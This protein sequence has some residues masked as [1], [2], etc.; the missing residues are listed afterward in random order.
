MNYAN[1]PISCLSVDL[2]VRPDNGRIYALA[3]VRTDRSQSIRSVR[4]PDA[5]RSL[6]R[7]IAQLDALAD[8]VD[9][10]LG[11]NIIAHDMPHLRAENPRLRLLQLPL[12]DTLRLSPL[13]HPAHPYH[14]LVKHY[15]EPGLIRGQRNDPHLDSLLALK[16]FADQYEALSGS[17][18]DLLTAW[19]WL[20][21][22]DEGTVGFDMVF[23][24]VRGVARPS[25][26]SGRAAAIAR[27]QGCACTVASMNVLDSEASGWPLAFA[28]AWL[29]VAE[30]NSVMPP[31]VR[32]QFPEAGRLV[33]RL[34]DRACSDADCEWCRDRHDAQAELKRW[35]GFDN[36][37]PEPAYRHGQ[38][39][40]RLVVEAAMAGE[41]LLAI[42]PTGAGKSLCY[43]VPALSRYA[44]TGALTVVISPL[45]ALMADQVAGLERR[46]ISAAVTINGMLSMPE[47]SD[48]LDRVRLGEAGI[49]L[50]SPEQL[51][52]VAIRRTLQQREI[53][54]WVL[55]EA[56]CLSQWGHDFRPDYRYVGRFIRER[57]REYPPPV[58][59]LTATAKPDVRD[60]IVNY[61]RDAMDVE[62]R[63]FDTG[64][65]R[66]N[67]EFVVVETSDEQK[68]E[69]VY[70]LLGSV[71]ADNTAGGAI[72]YCATRTRTEQMAA[73]LREKDVAASH[74][75]AG[76]LPDTKRSVQ[77]T[78]INGN[79]QVIAATSA[80]GMGI[81]KP[82]V[83]VV[84]HADIPGSL[85]NYLQE[86]GRA[87]RDQ[88]TARCVLLYTTQDVERQFG[89]SARSRLQRREIQAVM[90]AL[91]NLDRKQRLDG[92]VEATT[93][94]ILLEDEG[95]E[96][97][98]DSA[99]D[100]TRVRTAVAWLE[101]AMLVSREENRVRV[102]PSSLRVT[103]IQ[104][105]RALLA[106]AKITDEH[107]SRL[108]EIVKALFDAPA[109]Q[110]ISTD[111][112]M[113]T[114]GLS[115]EGVRAALHNL[116][117]LGIASNDTV[118]TVFVHAG[119]ARSSRNRLQAAM[120]LEKALIELLREMAPDMQPGDRSVF[121]LRHATQRLKSEGHEGALPELLW[122]LLRSIARD[123]RDEGGTSGSL[124]VRRHDAETVQVT[125]RRTWSALRRTAELRRAAARRLLGHFLGLLPTGAQGTDLLAETTLG[126]LVTVLQADLVI[127]SETRDPN[128]L[129]DRA[130]LWL[131][132][133][134]VIQLN[135]G[136]TVFRPAMAIRIEAERRRR[137]T[138]ADFASLLIHYDEQVRQIHVMAEYAERGLRSMTGA[139][140]LA[141]DYFSL[142]ESEF[143]RRWLPH[144][145]AE[146]SRQT[147]AES[148]RAIVEN[149]K[150]PDQRAI[151]ADDRESTNMLVLAG[152]GSG[153]TRVL[154][155]RIA[156]L[157]R[158][159]RENPRSII[160]LTYN[161]H[162]AI[163]IR[164]RLA[165]LVGDDARGVLVMTCH[166]L[167]MRLVGASYEG[168]SHQP[169]SDDFDEILKQAIALLRGD[170][171]PPD[172]ADELRGRLLAGFR[173]VLI[174]E[175]QDIT[176]AQYDLIS[177][178]AGRTLSDA[179]SK[180]T[181][182]AVGDD[183]QNIYAFAGASV[184]FIRRFA[185]DYDAHSSY[186]TGN[187]RSTRH[188]IEAANA[189]IAPARERMKANHPIGIDRARRNA[190][191]GGVWEGRDPVAGG[192][193]QVLPAGDT[194]LSQAQAAINELKRLA[195]LDPDW[196]WSRCAFIAREWSLLDPVRSLCEH[197]GIPAQLAHEEISSIWRL[198]ETQALV[199]W[200]RERIAGTISSQE[201]NSW[202]GQQSDGPWNQLL[203]EAVDEYELETGGAETPR[204][205]A[206]EWLAEWSREARRRQRG[207]ILLT[208]H[209]AKGLEFDH[210]IVLDGNWQ[211]VS[212]GE[213]TDAPRR[214]YYVAM[215]RARQTLGLMRFSA[216]QPL[217][218]PLQDVPAVLHRG[219]I[220]DM[221]L[222]PRQLA[223]RY[224]R[225]S[226]Q[227]VF[228]SFAGYRSDNHRVHRAITELTAGDRLKVRPG[229]E[230][231]SLM[232]KRGVEVGELA[233]AFQPPTGMRCVA[234]TVLAIASW[235]RALVS[236]EHL[237]G[238]R[239]DSWE[240]VIPELV[241]E[242]I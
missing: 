218:A 63:V 80:F 194:A 116:E 154:V 229:P 17:A 27:L 137:F 179:D 173:W 120:T 140:Q 13:A 101:E 198:R 222:P 100:D 2:E 138:D 208:A 26:E 64:A 54:A 45:V 122:R 235:E 118:I 44:K 83:R 227:K 30:G 184:E 41:N 164:R 238:L 187:Y 90:R 65:Q 189:V 89:L 220:Q 6:A 166:A 98:R 167:A 201:I 145:S 35:F 200:L 42:L 146:T 28:L 114:A 160:A 1:L 224:V 149:L 130:L 52:S 159:R 109:D 204:E 88:R 124:S 239:T 127:R 163:E 107:R 165:D 241:F 43:Q 95:K 131:H 188:I 223:R 202:I 103:S 193:V 50:I 58:W 25:A 168:R 113:Y 228:I 156:Y 135:R 60:D 34:R 148:W 96:F 225:L 16:L 81:D 132:E 209:R 133:Q 112:L 172:E 180:L 153:K 8:G 105:A 115:P 221:P 11:H 91:R 195:A 55:D 125:L 24:C 230:R 226:L 47:R 210:V 158:V 171:L 20:T 234:A 216:P 161:R 237:E 219:T 213:D 174:D 181:M 242:P 79:L 62:L 143:L 9:S 37:R 108:L 207:L 104:Q 29:S 18:P 49:L 147:T 4:F 144:R 12:I 3:G 111:E 10:L 215:T 32:Y 74:F 73:F 67:L 53:G 75:H 157:L 15:H 214:L 203:R 22:I 33:Q 182:L 93:G 66:T 5:T 36:F 94:E 31:W 178:L 196:D 177:A 185:E 197:E 85:E 190:S 84:I 110:G 61:F 141:M 152:P 71:L 139:L 86:A 7:A 69:N 82:D 126:K 106:R 14:H 155:Q 19:H 78:F 56:H 121:H 233:K 150:N 57:A 151:V 48:A 192:R 119:I 123:G 236:P 142:P 70:Q 232:D 97:E 205:H 68:F 46:G 92:E 170:G 38:S 176:S 102:F 134:Q 51:R 117:S 59:C 169:G 191:P 72:V 87:G 77:E 23:S 240:V 211:R 39:V 76:L 129:M 183:D 217:Q 99:T 21:T 231:W 40:Q 175:Y 199:R 186:L 212:H 128:K 162:A 206:I 136:L